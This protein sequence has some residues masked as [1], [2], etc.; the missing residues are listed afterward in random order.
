MSDKSTHTCDSK[1]VTFHMICENLR[2]NLSNLRLSK[3]L[4]TQFTQI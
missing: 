4:L 3:L 2:M 1:Q